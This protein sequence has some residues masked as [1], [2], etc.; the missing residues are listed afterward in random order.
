MQFGLQH[1][2][3]NF[4]FDTYRSWIDRIEGLEVMD[5]PNNTCC[6]ASPKG[7]R[8]VVK[9]AKDN[10]LDYIVTPCLDCRSNLDSTGQKVLLVSTLLLEALTGNPT[11]A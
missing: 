2:N 1:P 11:T 10:K 5:L 9:I 7:R 8:E 4:D 3:F 6:Q